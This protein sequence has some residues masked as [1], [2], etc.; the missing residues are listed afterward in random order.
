MS[1]PRVI[2]TPHIGFVTTDELDAQF[3]TIYDQVRAFAEGQAVNVVNPE[4]ACR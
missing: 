4:S 2:P 3:A 1:H